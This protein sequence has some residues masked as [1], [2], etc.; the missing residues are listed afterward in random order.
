MSAAPFR[1]PNG[2]LVPHSLQAPKW[3]QTCGKEMRSKGSE[4]K[5]CQE[6]KRSAF[7][8]QHSS[9]HCVS[10]DPHFDFQDPSVQSRSTRRT[11]EEVKLLTHTLEKKNP[12]FVRRPRYWNYSWPLPTSYLP[13]SP[14][15]TAS[16]LPL[17]KFSL[18][19]LSASVSISLYSDKIRNPY[20]PIKPHYHDQNVTTHTSVPANATHSQEPSPPHGP[21]TTDTPR[22]II[23]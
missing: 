10:S 17:S 4:T 7:L 15:P 16:Q 18:W 12:A 14:A 13:F 21:V 1:A 22:A 5:S 6:R 9:F 19:S 20:Y 2:I 3:L 11:P 23:V 8:L